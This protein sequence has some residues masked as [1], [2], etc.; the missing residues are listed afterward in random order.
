MVRSKF[1]QEKL[2]ESFLPP[3]LRLWAA[4]ADV[5]SKC[6]PATDMALLWLD[7]VGSTELTHRMIEERPAG[8]EQLGSR[9]QRHFDTLITIVVEHGGEPFMFAG[10]GLLCGWPPGH[11]TP[12][13][14]AL[15]AA[16]CAESLLDGKANASLETSVLPLHAVLAFGSCQMLD[17][18]TSSARVYITVGEALRDLQVATE[19]PAAP[20]QLRVSRGAIK[21]LGSAAE[22]SPTM[23]GCGVLIRLHEHLPPAPLFPVPLPKSKVAWFTAHVPP[24][25]TARLT[26][27]QLDWTTSL[28]LVTVVF[29]ALPDL[30][31]AGADVA[32]RLEEVVLA[33]MPLVRHYDGQFY[34]LLV[35]DRGANLL[36]LFGPPPVAHADDSVRG[37]RMAIDL[38][39]TLR[40]I[41]HH[42]T[43][44]VATSH[45]LCGLIGNDTFRKYMVFGDAI[46]LASRLKGRREGAIQCDEATVRGARSAIVFDPAGRAQV[47]GVTAPIG[48]WTPR[49][50]D[51]P[52]VLVPM[53]GRDTELGTLKGA[54]GAAV[55]GKPPSVVLI[56][57][58]TG[59]GKSRLLAE[60]RKCVTNDA[61]VLM[62]A[63]DRI[64]GQVPYHSWRGIF[65]Q[66]FGID[67]LDKDDI[68]RERVRQAL[69]AKGADPSLLNPVL[70]FQFPSSQSLS[71]SEQQQARL[72]LLLSLLR[73]A[74]ANKTLL[75]MI[76]DAHWLDE[77]SW[78]LAQYVAR[79]VQGA[80]LVLSMQPLGDET[81]LKALVAD[82]ATRLKLGELSDAEQERLI[83][84][85]L[86]VERVADE[87]TKLVGNRAHGNPFFC[88][89]LAQ[90]LLEEGIIEVSNGACRITPRVGVSD[91]PLPDTIKGTVTRRI[92]RLEAGP[93][94][95][96]K[97]ASVAG[98]RFPTSLVKDV[99]P[100][101]AERARVR[102]H[103]LLN[104]CI[105]LLIPDRID[106]LEG[107]AFRHGI[108]R[109]V[110]YDLMP[111]AYEPLAMPR[112]ARGIV[113]RK[114]LHLRIAEWYEHTYAHDQS[115]Y[116]A[117]LAHHLEAAGEP[118]RAARYLEQEAKRTFRLGLARQSVTIGLRAARSLGLDLP[119]DH[120][121]ICQ[122]LGQE[123]GRI[124]VLLKGRPPVELTA[125]PALDDQKIDQLLELLVTIGPFAYQSK[126]IEL[127]ALIIATALRL[128][129]EHGNG[130]NAAKV[131]SMFSIV[132]GELSGDRLEA[133][134]WSRLALMLNDTHDDGSPAFV[135]GW[136]H[137][138]WVGSLEDSF[139]GSVRAADTAEANNNI[140]Y[141]CFNLAAAVIYLASVGRPL[142]DVM[143]TAQV[144]LDRISGRVMNAAFHVKLEL[145]M[146][147]ALA[148]LTRDPLDLT[149][150]QFDEEQD[151]AFIRKTEFGNQI[152]YYLVSLTK[153]RTH[154]GDWSGAL[155]WSE[156][157][158][159]DE[160]GKILSSFRGQIAECEL[161]QFHGLAALAQ[162][163]FD[164]SGGT[165]ARRE[166][167]LDCLERLR[168]WNDNWNTLN[169]TKVSM[170]NHKADLLDGILAAI[171]EWNG[172]PT[173]E[174][175][176]TLLKRAAQGALRSSP[177]PFLPDAVLAFEFLARYYR[178]LGQ[179][180]N[181][182]RALEEALNI[183][184][185]WGAD[186]KLA[187]LQR[188]FSEYRTA[189]AT[190]GRP[191]SPTGGR[192]HACRDRAREGARRA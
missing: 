23:R 158:R 187:F 14:A 58:E 41:G 47:K 90:T 95:T 101:N 176:D 106:E 87:V 10:D 13:D 21:I 138:H 111:E 4:S 155:D 81:R 105:G 145:Q 89:E 73:D 30:D 188:E 40:S 52:E 167:G 179:S 161:V 123:L 48:V 99:H 39:D 143:D 120:D 159:S 149:D 80:C 20:C 32:T 65:A 1:S 184:K 144:H 62:A 172:E 134:A 3:P 114:E 124:E 192:A 11:G 75:I 18:G 186:A 130:P 25:V 173:G 79:E 147:K 31:C 29:A 189:T 85:R 34:E 182:S 51:K 118:E 181:A 94:L 22:I 68:R 108:I 97:V 33:L 50:Q 12:R 115:R 160:E 70:T 185:S 165:A 96:L 93:Q 66:L 132:H 171:K 38:R 175:A 116:Y 137:N 126:Q 146:A 82:G 64:E 119:V 37:V 78:E 69:K 150:E 100:I 180:D 157:A 67:R 178:K 142:Q 122:E 46:N 109:D 24:Q 9:L 136:F 71:P 15:R 44:G 60:F 191:S 177:Q 169:P 113:G 45:A 49:R 84:V 112:G 63:A 164:P 183:C 170:F 92:D 6:P 139:S 83:C 135:H 133:A 43:I 166:E 128:T 103:L 174:K 5:N 16:Q 28:R 168:S 77:A 141:A 127:Y 53:H 55:P 56:E 148:G 86:G 121:A 72:A 163:A 59:I 98:L 102:Q 26:P 117:L 156:H 2:V 151:L 104:N 152:G 27:N 125:L 140:E 110:A 154:F 190:K 42:S 36:V 129:L 8:I 88:I 162:V 54:L 131:Y 74:A 35:D 7:I 76:D 107:Y 91:L 19:T 17:I 61:R 57:G 153:L